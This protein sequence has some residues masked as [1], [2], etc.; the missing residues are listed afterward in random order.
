MKKLNI[1]LL[2][3]SDGIIGIK[4]FCNYNNFL[5]KIEFGKTISFN[6]NKYFFFI[7]DLK[8]YLRL[9]REKKYIE[10][11][12][13]EYFNWLEIEIHVSS[14]YILLGNQMLVRNAKNFIKKNGIKKTNFIDVFN[15][16]TCKYEKILNHN[17]IYS[18]PVNGIH[19]YKLDIE[20]K[21]IVRVSQFPIMDRFI[22]TDEIKLGQI[23]LNN[24]SLL[25]CCNDTE[26]KYYFLG[27]VIR[28]Q[29][30]DDIYICES[31]I[32]RNGMI[33]K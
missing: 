18:K 12:E 19:L 16:E 28:N 11:L 31:K 20:T 21:K 29:K 30:Y 14:L 15:F 7:K 9:N 8:L 32:Y 6:G 24:G 27:K 33:I 5:G 13:L 1:T 17:E 23:D 10:L 3:M 26:K 2:Y 22:K 25:N 4:R